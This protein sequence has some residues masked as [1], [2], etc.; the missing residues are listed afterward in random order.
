M[1]GMSRFRSICLAVLGAGVS[2]VAVVPGTAAASSPPFTDHAVAGS[3]TLCG[4]SGQPVTSGNLLTA[5]FVW[6]AVSSVA[7][8]AG[9]TRAYLTLYQ[10]RKDVDPGDWTGYQLTEDSL[11]SNAEH[12]IAQATNADAPLLYAD[13]SLPP[14]WDGLFELRMYFTGSG[15]PVETSPYPAAVI[16]VT[17]NNWTLVQ[18]GGTRC[19]VGTAVSAETGALP[20]SELSSPQSILVG[21]QAAT[22][23]GAGANGAQAAV[24]SDGNSAARSAEAFSGKAST[25]GAGT[26]WVLPTVSA[27]ALTAGATALGLVLKR[28]RRSAA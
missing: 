17:G 4:R 27:L 12:P 18:G 14:Q 20:K 6:S 1:K 15:L 7:A 2:L 3:L 24:G 5:P 13:R 11:F 28:R 10:P 23:A 25:T 21:S 9:Y 19:N 16:R 26:S 22:S 8:P